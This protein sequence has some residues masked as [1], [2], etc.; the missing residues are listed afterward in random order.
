MH[1]DVGLFPREPV[2]YFGGTLVLAA[3]RRKEAAEDRGRKPGPLTR[4]LAGLA[5]PGLLPVKGGNAH[6]NR[7]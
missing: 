2:R 1:G 5:H 3:N 7:D 6:R 4:T